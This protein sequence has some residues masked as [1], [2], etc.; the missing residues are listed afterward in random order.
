M[1]RHFEKEF[2]ELKKTIIKMASVVDE[3]VENS[4]ADMEDAEIHNFLH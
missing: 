3:Q 2:D 4:F 1:E